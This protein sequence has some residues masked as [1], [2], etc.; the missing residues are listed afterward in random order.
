[1]WC[2]GKK[3]QFV[4]NMKKYAEKCLSEG[5]IWLE[6]LVSK[7]ISV[8]NDI[9]EQIDISKISTDSKLNEKGEKLKKLCGVSDE[10]K[11]SIGNFSQGIKFAINSCKGNYE[12]TY[13]N[14][15]QQLFKDKNN[16]GIKIGSKTY[17]L[18]N[19]PDI[20]ENVA[21]FAKRT[22][23]KKNTKKNY[24]SLQTVLVACAGPVNVIRRILK[25]KTNSKKYANF[26]KWETELRNFVS[27]LKPQA[28]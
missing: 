4:E 7:Y 15:I 28:Q 18:E 1:M 19:Y 12:K 26:I 22:A 25:N 13:W 17:Y 21:V 23:S 8:W 6:I 5:E 3:K 9:S 24:S 14:E 10:L 20:N 11:L 27:S 16:K 2:F